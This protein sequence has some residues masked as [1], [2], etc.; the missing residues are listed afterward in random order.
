MSISID[1]P[2]V[3][4]A[5][6]KRRF[7]IG[8]FSLRLYVWAVVLFIMVPTLIIVPMSFSPADFLEFPPRGF[9]L[10]WYE[11]FFGDP[12]WQKATVLS[13]KVAGLT[14]VCS[15]I[16]GTMASYAIVRGTAWFRSVTQLFIIGPVIAPHIAVAVA[17][18]L[19]YQRLGV[20]GSLAG[21]VAA[22]TMLE[23]PFVI[24]TVSAA[25][26]RVDPDLESAA[27]SCGASRWSA[28]FHVTLPLIVPGLASGALFAFI[29]SFDEPVVS[30][31][32][33]SVRQRTLPR[34]MFED[35]EQNLTPVI[36]AIA[37]LLTLLSV[38]V[39]VAVALLRMSERR[40]K[41]G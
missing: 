14:M 17:C 12:L 20:V 31:F 19:F 1:D 34:R 7:D 41:S 22:H 16:V 39:L 38:A 6:L 23:L 35:I 28:F 26:S 27:M 32:V 37:T 15:L 10:H 33:S 30:F 40:R 8:A 36:P 9:T 29:I 4:A 24:F 11:E 21:F 2:I 13:L 25:L 18:Y 5:G 3:R